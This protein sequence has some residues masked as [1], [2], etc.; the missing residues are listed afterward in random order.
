MALKCVLFASVLL[1]I[2]QIYRVKFSNNDVQR[3]NDISSKLSTDGKGP[4]VSKSISSDELS[5]SCEYKSLSDLKDYELHP[6]VSKSK[7]GN[8]RRHAY[9]PPKD[10]RVTLVCCNTT[11][12]PLSIA[13]HDNWAPL[14]AAR[15]LEM[16]RNEY[17]SS[18]V[19]LMRCVHNFIC[20]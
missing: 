20:Q 10:G 2:V 19:A 12:G 18:K 16:V 7:D 4:S 9:P 11:A 15:F 1:P 17:F 6:E 5:I 14:G 3:E 8:N 13:V